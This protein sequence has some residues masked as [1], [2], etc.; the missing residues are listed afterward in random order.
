MARLLVLKE[1]NYIQEEL[2]LVDSSFSP[3]F[4]R[5]SSVESDLGDV[6][7]FGQ[8]PKVPLFL[9]PPKAADSLK[10]EFDLLNTCIVHVTY[11]SL[12]T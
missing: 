3:F 11:I 12:T 7:T 2:T 4:M 10:K 6:W 9:S 8:W 1:V 5:G